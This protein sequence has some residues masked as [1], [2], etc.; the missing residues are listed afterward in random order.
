[1]TRRFPFVVLAFAALL[2]ACRKPP[3]P[4]PDPA[5]ALAD[6]RSTDDAQAS[7]AVLSIVEFG[8]QAVP[9]LID[10]LTDGDPRFRIR[11]ASALWLLETKSCPAVPGLAGLLDDPELE[12]R[13]SVAMA[14]SNVGSCGAPAVPRLIPALKDSDPAVRQYAAKALGAIGPA[15]AAAMP[16]L[17]EMS[18]F[19]ALR[20]AA[21]EAMRKIRGR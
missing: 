9:G 4:P 12:V 2:G 8:D 7:K 6:L 11:A 16:A 5:K 3:P 21:E 13:R 20:P 18:R 1:M 15:A 19:D 10:L 17:A 14:L